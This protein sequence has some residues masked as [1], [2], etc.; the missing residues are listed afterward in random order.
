MADDWEIAS[1][2]VEEQWQDGRAVQFVRVDVRSK[3]VESVFPL[4]I[5]F[6]KYSAEAV[7]EL[8]QAA[9][10]QIHAVAEL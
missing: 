3:R 10:D 5:P 1:Q 8:A 9:M 4:R 6:A 7:A 2:T